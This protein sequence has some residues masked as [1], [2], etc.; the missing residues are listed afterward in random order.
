MRE[1]VLFI[2]L[3]SFSSC[4]VIRP[5]EVGVKQKLGKLNK[6]PKS[7]GSIWFNPFT[8]KVIKVS[9]RTENLELTIIAYQVKK[10]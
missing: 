10:A 6:T 9:T 7:S 4:A 3:L 8:S 2:I 5:G 1:F